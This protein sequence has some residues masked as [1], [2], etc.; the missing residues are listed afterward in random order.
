LPLSQTK[1]E[2]FYAQLLD[3]PD[4]AILTIPELKKALNSV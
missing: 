4:Q 1:F 2:V 3:A